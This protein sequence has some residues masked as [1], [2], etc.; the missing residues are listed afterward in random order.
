MKTAISLAPNFEIDPNSLLDR[1][2]YFVDK[3]VRET[4]EAGLDVDPATI[5]N[6]YISLKSKPL[7]ILVG[8]RGV[9]KADFVRS[10]A[11]SLIQS[12]I[13]DQCQFMVGHPW[14]AERSEKLVS[15]GYLQSQFNAEKLHQLFE[16]A[17]RIEN[18]KLLYIACLNAISPAEVSGFF[19]EIALQLQT[20][21]IIQLPEF[22]LTTPFIYPNNLQMIGTIDTT[23]FEWY[24]ENLLPHTNIIQLPEEGKTKH[25]S[26]RNLSVSNIDI[27]GE[28]EFLNSRI[29]DEGI[30]HMKLQRILKNQS[31][32]LKPVL[33][34]ESVLL[35]FGAKFSTRQ[36]T[37]EAVI[38]LSNAWTGAGN[39]LFDRS[40][41]RN[42]EIALD[43]TISQN[44]LPR[45]FPLI[46]E[47]D[48]LRTALLAMLDGKFP[49]VHSFIEGSY[50]K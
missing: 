37:R 50:R 43:F 47:S 36:V 45:A 10:I 31:L 1:E 40:D 6:F 38:Y 44:V 35:K 11:K 9:G 26:D 2:Q 17:G 32:A 13:N 23:L 8:S 25:K 24:D 21:R 49:N 12:K 5:V 15:F 16:D 28:R 18:D 41:A 3:L 14:W 42:L 30:A 19:S 4:V 46:R 29:R 33:E 39:G 7:A 22:T 20:S 27:D 34:I 48:R